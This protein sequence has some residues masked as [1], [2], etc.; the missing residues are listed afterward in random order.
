MA[1]FKRNK[2]EE[3]AKEKDKAKEEKVEVSASV[4]TGL[5]EGK[6]PRLYRIIEKSVLTEKAVDLSGKNK[7]VFKVWQ[8]TNKREIRKAI[9]KLYEVKVREVKIINTR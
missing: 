8:K 7:Y 2:K 3:K 5:P 4:K 9:E 6:D 1:L